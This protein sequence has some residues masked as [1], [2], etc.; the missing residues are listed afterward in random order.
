VNWSGGRQI[1]VADIPVYLH[2]LTPAV[3]RLDTRI[4]DHG[5]DGMHSTAR[6]SVFQAGTAVLVDAHG[7]PRVRDLAVTPSPRRPP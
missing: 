6:Q 3:L 7:V 4:T 2:E 5:F 1:T